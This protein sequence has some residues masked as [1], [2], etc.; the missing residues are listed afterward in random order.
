MFAERKWI[1]R[2]GGAF[3][4][5]LSYP[6][7]VVE[8]LKASEFSWVDLV[9]VIQGSRF[10]AAHLWDE[11]SRLDLDDTYLSFKVPMV[12]LLGRYDRQVPAVLAEAYLEKLSA[13][14]KRLFW[15]E[16]SAHN[17]PFEESE[18]FNRIM[19]DDVLPVIAELGA[20]ARPGTQSEGC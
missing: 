9:K 14:Y 8:A 12:F 3:H 7:L 2:F 11:M 4:A 19:V 17:P 1:N 20:P 5:D 6:Q 15:F 13:P 16:A 18:K 10:S